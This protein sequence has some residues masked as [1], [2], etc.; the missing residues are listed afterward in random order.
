M[1]IFSLSQKSKCQKRNVHNLHKEKT[2]INRNIL[3]TILFIIILRGVIVNDYEIIQKWKAGLTKNKLAEIYRRQFNQQIR[4]IRSSTR[5]RHDGKFI[6]N[7]ES[8]AHVE[9]IIYKYLK[10]NNK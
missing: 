1:V 3:Y 9:K 2:F 6:T 10:N 5:H 8:L 7:Y 4:I